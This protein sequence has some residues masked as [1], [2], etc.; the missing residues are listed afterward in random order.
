MTKVL[1]KA[2]YKR[3][4][5]KES[6]ENFGICFNCFVTVTGT[7]INVILNKKIENKERAFYVF[8]TLLY[9]K[10]VRKKLILQI[11]SKLYTT[12]KTFTFK[13]V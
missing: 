8:I 13:Y 7:V 3:L 9:S 4:Q 5:K 1:I 10:K 11:V 2:D 6:K 12:M